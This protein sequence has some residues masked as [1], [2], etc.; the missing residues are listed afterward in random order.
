MN[1]CK[2]INNVNAVLYNPLIIQ[3]RMR[4]EEEKKNERGKKG[5]KKIKPLSHPLYPNFQNNVM[6]LF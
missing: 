6:T 4:K 2:Y 3:K 1:I 5:G